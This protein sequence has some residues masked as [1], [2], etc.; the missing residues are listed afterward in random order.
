MSTVSSHL[1]L[2]AE[3]RLLHFIQVARYSRTLQS[4]LRSHREFSCPWGGY[5]VLESGWLLPQCLPYKIKRLYVDPGQACSLQLHA[6][7]HEIW[8]MEIGVSSVTIK[9]KTQDFRQGQNLLVPKG[10]AHRIRNETQ[11][12]VC[13]L[14]IQFGE[15]LDEE[16]VMRLEDD[17]GRAEGS[18]QISA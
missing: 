16:D 13:V 7:R 18:A 4:D 2:L 15:V 5:G 1:V 9:D 6:H 10:L 14:E 8:H 3:K 11:T 17:Y 12:T